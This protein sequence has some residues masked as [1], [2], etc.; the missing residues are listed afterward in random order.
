ML[1]E[2][3][4]D[5]SNGGIFLENVGNENLL[6]SFGGINQG[7]GIPVFEFFNSITSLKCDKIFFRDFKQMWYQQGIDEDINGLI[8]FKD[9][10]GKKIQN[11]KY[12]KIVF[13]GNAM[14]GYA[15]ILFGYLL[16]VDNIIS[17]APQTFIDWKNRLIFWDRRW[18]KQMEIVYRNMN[19]YPEYFDLKKHLQITQEYTC[20]ID[21]YYSSKHRLDKLHAERLKSLKN[22]SL[23]PYSNGGHG[24]VKTLRDSGEL[25]LILSGLFI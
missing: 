16:N 23:H 19:K 10:I 4:T 8:D 7:L 20:K 12:K 15:A 22:V 13:V 3:T 18:R 11:K 21:V 5:R 14:G 1:Q 2:E 25:Q 9:F 24:V 17:F 6:V